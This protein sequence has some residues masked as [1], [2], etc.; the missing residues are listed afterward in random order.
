M[1][2]EEQRAARKIT[3]EILWIEQSI[4]SLVTV[5]NEKWKALSTIVGKEE[6]TATAC[7]A[8]SGGDIDTGGQPVSLDRRYRPKDDSNILEMTS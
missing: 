5:R 8:K 3:D 7:A 2:R 1:T 4:R 6:R